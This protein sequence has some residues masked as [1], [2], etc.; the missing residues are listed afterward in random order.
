MLGIVLLV[1]FFDNTH[2]E[3]VI[4]VAWIEGEIFH[5]HLRVR[6]DISH[7][8]HEELYCVSV[9]AIVDR[10]EL[11]R[12]GEVPPLTRAG[13]RDNKKKKLLILFRVC[14]GAQGRHR[15]VVI[16]MSPNINFTA[17]YDE[18]LPVGINVIVSNFL[19][20]LG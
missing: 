11:G 8:F 5:E 9:V 3:F 1:S 16:V 2:L 12:D 10:L 14:T 6:V 4:Q 19:K 15:R 18:I 20:K 7:A 13:E 17:S